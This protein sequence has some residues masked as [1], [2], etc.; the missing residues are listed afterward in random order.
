MSDVILQYDHE[1]RV[2]ARMSNGT[3]KL[4]VDE[5]GLWMEADLSK[6]EGARGL[7]EEI[8]AGMI[9]EMSFAF[10]VDKDRY[11]KATKTRI[12][13]RIKKVYDVSAVSIPANPGT[14]ISAR[15]Y[16][17]GVKDAEQQ[18]RLAAEERE[19][20]IAMIKLILEVNKR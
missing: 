15:D 8:R 12:V 13:E 17:N 18:E 7:Y 19:R 9:T 6:T 1:G 3:L 10:T 20:D 2:F 16:V 5:H 11:D 4:G 14:E